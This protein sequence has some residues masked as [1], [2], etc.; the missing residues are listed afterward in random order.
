MNAAL[1]VQTAGS[2][3]VDALKVQ[4]APASKKPIPRLMNGNERKV[5]LGVFS[6]LVSFPVHRSSNTRRKCA[7]LTTGAVMKRSTIAS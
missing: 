6:V 1:A 7:I 3:G 2:R 5:I 4:N